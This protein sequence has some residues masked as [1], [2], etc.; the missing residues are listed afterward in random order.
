MEANG[1]VTRRELQT[2][3]IEKCWKDPEFRRK[4]VADPKGLL[5]SDTGKKLPSDVKIFIH[6]ED[7]DTLHFSIPPTPS[8]ISEL[9]DADL[10]RVSGGT[11]LITTMLVA[12]SV[13]GVLGTVGLVSA[14]TV[15]AMKQEQGW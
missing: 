7:A 5:E 11:D 12:F 1:A 14:H 4:V 2:A 13:A 6:E 8:N 3:L 10:E 15:P 9:S